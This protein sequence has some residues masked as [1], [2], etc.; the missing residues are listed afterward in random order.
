ML[1]FIC[2]IRQFVLMKRS[3][4]VSPVKN[5]S[6]HCIDVPPSIFKILIYVKSQQR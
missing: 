1:V 5:A 3:E 6:Q 4:V 2:L